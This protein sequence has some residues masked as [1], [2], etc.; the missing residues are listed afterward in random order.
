VLLSIAGCGST[1]PFAWMNPSPAGLA[2]D[3]PS[4]QEC[5]TSEAVTSGSFGDGTLTEILPNEIPLQEM[6]Y[7]GSTYGEIPMTAYPVIEGSAVPEPIPA[8]ALPDS[9][10]P[11][12]DGEPVP[13]PEPDPAA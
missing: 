10:E 1:G 8:E 13:T 6:P 9:F 11:R 7:D 12:S 3:D 5:P 2:C 4:C